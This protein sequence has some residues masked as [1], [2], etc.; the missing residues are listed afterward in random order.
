MKPSGQTPLEYV[1]VEEQKRLNVA[2][3]ETFYARSGDWFA[4]LCVATSV[5]L[6]L[7]PALARWWIT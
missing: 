6:I 5:V 1:Q 7:S 3:E 4:W 2:R